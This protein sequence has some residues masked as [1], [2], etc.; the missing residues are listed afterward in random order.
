[1]IGVRVRDGELLGIEPLLDRKAS[2]TAERQYKLVAG[3]PRTAAVR[4]W[5]Y[6]PLRLNYPLRRTGERGE[7]KWE[8][9]SWEQALDEIAQKLGEIKDR[10]GA[11]GIAICSNGENN[12]AEEYRARFQS[13]L[14]TPNFISHH[15][16]CFG[17]AVTLAA[18]LFGAP[19]F[20][21]RITKSTRCIMMIGV[22]PRPNFPDYWYR[23]Q[24]RQK[25][26]A[27]LIVVDPRRTSV[28]ERADIWLPLKPATDGALL[29]AMLNVI[30]NEGLYDSDFVNNYCYGFDRLC[31]HLK[32]Y[33]PSWASRICEVPED[34]IVEAAR[35][36]ATVKPGIIMHVMGM[37]QMF[38][39]TAAAHA[40]YILPAITGNLNTRGGEILDEPNPNTVPIA[41]IEAREKL[42]REQMD[43][44]IGKEFG[45]ASRQAFEWLSKNRKKV[46]ARPLAGYWLLPLVAH[47]PLVFR[48][49][50]TGKPYPVKAMITEAINPMLTYPNTKLVYEAT[51]KL[52]L[53]VAMDT[54]MTPTCQLGDY[55][56]PAASPLEKP[57]LLGG[58]YFTYVQ[59]GA[60]AL[61]PEYQRKPEYYLWRGLGLRLGQEEYWPWKTLED[62]YDYRL[63]PMGCTFKEFLDKGGFDAPVND[64]RNFE[65]VGFA[66]TT[67]KV[68]LYSTLLEELG[69]G[70]LPVYDEAKGSM[71]T[72]EFPMILLNGR[73]KTRNFCHSQWRQIES[74]RRRMPDPIVEINPA[75][76]R[77]LGIEDGDWVWIETPLGRAQF[78]SQ[79]W[80][81]IDP[82]QVHAEFGWWFPEDPGEE[83]SLHGVWRS[84]VNAL[85][86]DSPEICDPVS[87]QWV[88]RGVGC[89]VYKA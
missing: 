61:E 73:G 9:I 35:M 83:P 2:A 19:A 47:A 46:N 66:T 75:K 85:I 52:D 76:A 21:P 29:L 79:F 37:E 31:E 25:N 62:A 32:G 28:A 24:E 39:A 38:N 71:L 87:G 63:T 51:K 60:A 13:L 56:L 7:N 82:Q 36:Y 41:E 26:G 20:Y 89:K 84:N 88:M 81:G 48:A 17:A 65:N 11:E 45:L 27:K 42:G 23:I 16:V 70:P 18:G 14:G 15:Q 72:E 40:R 3:C 67:G 22:N 86:D 12:C 34:K 30:I 10:Y 58:E 5:F 55:V 33:A 53:H 69:Y 44:M 78:K 43:K 4:E 57:M 74:V 1:M 80:D 49:M 50:I 8:R 54:F 59:G 64:F 6:H 68:E 77:E